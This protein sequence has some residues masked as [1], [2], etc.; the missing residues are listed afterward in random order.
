MLTRMDPFEIDQGPRTTPPNA[1]VDK[2]IFLNMYFNDKVYFPSPSSCGDNVS[3]IFQASQ[4]VMDWW[5][6][7]IISSASDRLTLSFD[8]VHRVRPIIFSKRG[9]HNNIGPISTEMFNMA[10]PWIL[11]ALATFDDSRMQEGRVETCSIVDH[12]TFVPPQKI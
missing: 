11:Q 12:G 7:N 5:T 3:E 9:T 2:L 10:L 1:G 4:A 8:I 6:S